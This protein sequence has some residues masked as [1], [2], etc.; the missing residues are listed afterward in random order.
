[1]YSTQYAPV[2]GLDEQPFLLPTPVHTPQHSLS[3]TKSHTP[4]GHR[5]S[6]HEYRKQQATPPSPPSAASSDR[7]LKRRRGASGL[8]GVQRNASLASSARPSMESSRSLRSLLPAREVAGP[9]SFFS[10]IPPPSLASSSPDF[11]SFPGQS[12]L[13]LVFS[14]DLAAE[15]NIAGE[16]TRNFRPIKHLP[17][18]EL[19]Q[20]EQVFATIS[21]SPFEAVQG[22]PALVARPA[23]TSPTVPSARFSQLP[24]RTGS[25]Q[26][27]LAA[28]QAGI[29]H[30]TLQ[31]PIP[32]PQQPPHSA[33]PTV[34]HYR[35]VSFDLVNPHHSLNLSRI[36]T[37]DLRHSDPPDYF[38][39]LPNADSPLLANMSPGRNADIELQERPTPSR[40]LYTDLSTAHEAIA[41]RSLRSVKSSESIRDDSKRSKSPQPPMPSLVGYQT[42]VSSDGVTQP[43]PIQLPSKPTRSGSVRNRISRVWRRGIDSFRVMDHAVSQ[44]GGN[45]ATVE[46]QR[47]MAGIPESSPSAPEGLVSGPADIAAGHGH[48][49]RVSV[50]MGDLREMH[51]AQD[52][53]SPYPSSI[54]LQDESESSGYP[55][56]ILDN[57][58]SMALGHQAHRTTD[59]SDAADVDSYAF[60]FSTRET[61]RASLPLGPPDHRLST[62]KDST[63][64]NILDR[65]RDTSQ[66]SLEDV[67][68]EDESIV[69]LSAIDLAK[70]PTPKVSTTTLATR[71]SSRG[72]ST[73]PSPKTPDAFSFVP[74]YAITSPG[75]PPMRPPPELLRSFRP[76]GLRDEVN[77]SGLSDI[78]SAETYGDTRELLMLSQP[79]TGGSNLA[80]LAENA[81]SS[82]QLLPEAQAASG[83]TSPET[84]IRVSPQPPSRTVSPLDL[85]GIRNFSHPGGRSTPVSPLGERPETTISHRVYATPSEYPREYVDAEDMPTTPGLYEADR[86]SPEVEDARGLP[87]TSSPMSQRSSG[88]PRM[89][90]GS[91]PHMK[92]LQEEL[93]ADRNSP[94]EDSF[95]DI[96]DDEENDG[97]W[98]TVAD[99]SRQ[100]LPQQQ[101]MSSMAGYTDA[102]F[103]A[104]QGLLPALRFANNHNRSSSRYSEGP[105]HNAAG[106]VSSNVPAFQYSDRPAIEASEGNP[107]YQPQPSSEDQLVP[108]AL[109]SDPLSSAS[110]DTAPSAKDF[111]HPRDMHGDG[112]AERKRQQ[113]SQSETAS[114][115]RVGN[116]WSTQNLFDTNGPNTISQL[117]SSGPNDEILYDGSSSSAYYGTSSPLTQS[118]PAPVS[119]EPIQHEDSFS[120]FT[121][122]GPKA[123]LTGTPQGT[124]MRDAGSSLANTSSPPDQQWSSTPLR[125]FTSSPPTVE[126]GTPELADQAEDEIQVADAA[127][128]SVR[129]KIQ[130]TTPV[131]PEHPVSPASPRSHKSAKS[132]KDLHVADLAA[133]HAPRRT[134]SNV[135]EGFET[136]NLADLRER[137]RRE[138]EEKQ[139]AAA[140]KQAVAKNKHKR[141]SVPGQTELREMELV[142]K[143]GGSPPS[144]STV[145][146]VG[147]A[148]QTPMRHGSVASAATTTRYS[149]IVHTDGST[150]AGRDSSDTG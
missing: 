143:N 124:N 81:S 69:R 9:T 110:R 37:P 36:E 66:M 22:G 90:S 129:G 11:R 33:P 92:A 118:S 125:P 109:F 145:S 149:N 46:E 51:A 148:T 122:L 52:F 136:G 61:A 32:S 35:G 14:P 106:R 144:P 62:A 7:R 115:Q 117:L 17:R 43:Q 38:Q 89:W 128:P 87:I 49:K 142:R 47:V 114:A 121:V 78:A 105:Y 97:D 60:E 146:Q 53:V 83:H 139:L 96:E 15:G 42:M 134:S 103:I 79:L 132:S 25:A 98:E 18:K 28:T 57:S 91:P 58:S 141:A 100:T 54:Y 29:T 73:A 5:L 1:M 76:L 94:G 59:S 41:T 23:T 26:S 130:S 19:S 3:S 140:R 104:S 48:L 147:Q 68:T 21:L 67:Q 45:I 24:R 2:P 135:R 120:K 131:P 126:R 88:V 30:Q 56:S 44:Q 8:N 75:L 4:G 101:T 82:S 138:R 20:P 85:T 12:R 77:T 74:H 10:H 39:A 108:H 65:Y 72:S 116:S 113:I 133:Q 50:S 150:A 93:A 63:I 84:A 107:Y 64:D 70:Q 40:M 31:L 55:L 86:H 34:L 71:I 27:A 99:P 123:N 95:A 112:E 137:K 102:S 111:A 119:S 6:I 13:P 127:S 16:R 80:T